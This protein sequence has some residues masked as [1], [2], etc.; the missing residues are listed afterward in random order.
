[1]GSFLLTPFFLDVSAEETY[2]ILIPTGSASPNA[3]Y[4][5]QS[6]KDGDTSGNI[7][8]I[9]G[10]T[11]VWKNADTATH[12][13]TSG[14]VPEPDNLFDSG[15]FAPGKFFSY[16]FT[17]PG[18]IPYFCIVH[19]WM[20]GIV[21]VSAGYS[22]IPNVGLQIGDGK[23]SFDVEYK[24]NRVLSTAI[25]DEDQKSITFEIIGIPKSDNHDLEILL[26]VELI[27]GPFVMW[28]DD[29]KII[30]FELN[31]KDNMNALTIPLNADAKY[32]T[33][34][35]TSIV[36]E[37]GPIVMLILVASIVPILFLSKRFHFS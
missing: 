25:I 7:D 15:L 26:P 11:V 27:D 24:L 20:E 16:T 2:D 35:G 31:K 14:M 34:I 12:T 9:V 3:P 21:S 33:I 18:N 37:F 4:F 36:P 1:M 19:P 23:T 22:I 30:D 10:D 5:W 29:E 13:V 32:L 17:E 28:V 6:E 8:I